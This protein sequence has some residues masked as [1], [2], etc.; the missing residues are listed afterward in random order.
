MKKTD[1]GTLTLADVGRHVKLQGWLHRRRP[2][3]GLTFLNVRDRSGVAQVVLRPDEHPEAT[4]ALEP[5]RLEWVIEVEG[6]VA[7]RAATAVNPEMATGEVEIVAESG[8]VLSP[9]AP[10]PFAPESGEDDASEETRLR[11]RYLDLRRPELQ[12]N[13]MLRDSI[14]LEIR[15]YFRERGF[16]HVE[17]P[18]LTRSTPEG[19]RD[20]LVP[21]RV[22]RGSFYALPQSPQ[23]FKQL[24]MVAGLERYVQI[25]R[26]F[27]DE[28]LR[29]NRQPEFTQLDVE[30]SFLSEDDIYELIEG[31][32]TRIFPLVGIEP[33]LPFRRMTWGEAMRRY[34]SDRPDLRFGLEIVEASDLLES[35]AFRA[36]RSTIDAGGVVR[37]VRAP[38]EAGASRKQIEAWAEIARARGAQGVLTLR[39]RDGRLEFQVKDVLTAGE[40]DALA[41]RI[42]LEDGDLAL[43]VAAPAPVAAAALGDLRL[44]LGR[45]GGLIAED[46]HEF[47][48]VTEFPLLEWDEASGRWFSCHHPFTAPLDADLENLESDPGGVRSRG[49]DVVL[50]GVELGGGSIRIHDTEL[51]ERAFRLLGIDERTARERFGFLLDA[52]RFGAPPHGGIA[53]GLD[54]MIMLMA[55]ADSLRDVIAFPKTTSATCLMTDAP[56]RVDERQLAELGLLLSE[57]GPE[58]PYG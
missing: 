9:S 46:R 27:R 58:D 13:L 6:V 29:A 56:S 52:L 26:C 28:D 10:L 39:R 43:L 18:I 33:Q 48:W 20:Y 17:T 4:A 42:G 54:R 31:L 40:L 35:S 55:G 7:A 30:M 38:D 50:N 14:F 51:Q 3:G 37:A 21:S 47:L 22:T 11:Y 24:L 15:K 36:F 34:G 19:A 53:L 12:R 2:H 1:A 44:D 41:E 5:A 45:R 23:L 32:F 49:Y 16:V 8:R 25:A 57:D